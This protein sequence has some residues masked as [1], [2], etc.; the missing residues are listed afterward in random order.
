MRSFSGNTF[1]SVCVKLGLVLVLT[2]GCT[3]EAFEPHFV[4]PN[5]QLRKSMSDA[6]GVVVGGA[7]VGLCQQLHSIEWLDLQPVV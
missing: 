4:S 2:P 6:N 5:A 3:H 7:N 1:G